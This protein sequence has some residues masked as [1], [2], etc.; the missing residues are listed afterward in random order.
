MSE[1]RNQR[2]RRLVA[3]NLNHLFE[4]R[5]IKQIVVEQ[6]TVIL[7]LGMLF[8]IIVQKIAVVGG[9]KARMSKIFYARVLLEI[10]S[11]GGVGRLVGAVVA[12]NDLEVPIR[13]IERAFERF[14]KK[15]RAVECRDQNLH[16]RIQL[17]RILRQKFFS[18]L[19]IHRQRFRA[20]PQPRLLLSSDDAF[21]SAPTEL[22]RLSNV[23]ERIV[24]EK[25]IA[26][27]DV[28]LRRNQKSVDRL[29]FAITPFDLLPI[30]YPTLR[31]RR[32]LAAS[33]CR[34]IRA[35]VGRQR[36]RARAADQTDFRLRAENFKQVIQDFRVENDR[37]VV[38]VNFIFGVARAHRLI[39]RAPTISAHQG[40]RRLKSVRDVEPR[41]HLFDGADVI[42]IGY[43]NYDR[44][45]LFVHRAPLNDET[46]GYA[47][48]PLRSRTCRRSR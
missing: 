26:P 47:S 31:A 3:I 19:L 39:K 48:S 13:L 15:L 5:R 40:C 17:R 38:D 9:G 37:P 22:E 11:N 27:I 28:V 30:K 12:D 1:R 32:H 4:L 10:R 35:A 25:I 6:P 23:A 24:V 20:V 2:H 29:N 36:E 7:R 43:V 14:R 45:F 21:I 8:L 18:T 44:D 16:L 33:F 42:A 34:L 41:E 46:G